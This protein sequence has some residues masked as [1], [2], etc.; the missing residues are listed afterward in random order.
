MH[1]LLRN[2][3]T[4]WLRDSVLNSEE[5]THPKEHTLIFF[6]QVVKTPDLYRRFSCLRWWNLQISRGRQGCKPR[7]WQQNKICHLHSVSVVVNRNRR[8]CWDSLPRR[9]EPARNRWRWFSRQS[10]STQLPIQRYCKEVFSTRLDGIVQI[11]D[12]AEKT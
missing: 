12:V 5:K 9:R 7:R 4:F 6:W 3:F 11:P 10:G 2:V 8:L 1:V